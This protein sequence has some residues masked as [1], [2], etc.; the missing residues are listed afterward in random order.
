MSTAPERTSPTQN[1]AENLP[2][3]GVF[4][5]TIRHLG[6]M[7]NKVA[8]MFEVEWGDGDLH[9]FDRRVNPRS[10]SGR[11]LLLAVRISAGLSDK[12]DDSSLEGK[13]ISIKGERAY[14]GGTLD[15]VAKRFLQLGEPRASEVAEPGIQ[16]DEKDALADRMLRHMTDAKFTREGDDVMILLPG[17]SPIPIDPNS[18]DY[19]LL[20]HQH[21]GVGTR[22]YKGKVV[23]QR[24]KFLA[25]AKAGSFRTVQFSYADQE[26]VLV[27]VEGGNVLRIGADG[28]S[29]L[30]NGANGFWLAHPRKNPLPWQPDADPREGLDKFEELLIQTQPIPIEP[31]RFILGYALGI[32]PFLRQLATTRP[33][34]ELG[35]RHGEGKTS[36]GQ[37]YLTQHRL[38]KVKGNYSLALRERDGDVGLTVIDNVE[39]ADLNRH[40]ENSLLYAATGGEWGR[41]GA[42][43]NSNHPVIAVTT[44]EGVARR[45]ETARRLLNLDFQRE[46]KAWPEGQILAD[47]EKHGGLIFRGIAEVIRLTMAQ[48]PVLETNIIPMVDFT[49]Y[50]LL[51]YRALRA[52]E[53]V[54]EKPAGF[55]DSIFEAWNDQQH[56]DEGEDS[57]GS[58]PRLLDTLTAR[59]DVGSFEDLVYGQI[60]RKS[61]YTHGQVTGDLFVASPNDWLT[62]LKDVA[63]RDRHHGPLPGRPEGLRRRLEGLNIEAHGYKLLTDKDDKDTLAR[64]GSRRLWGILKVSLDEPSLDNSLILDELVAK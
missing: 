29:I 37:R 5:A 16:P 48:D 18:D 45:P 21:T 6:L 58:Y 51:A 22:E 13:R 17:R 40:I 2:P 46:H 60:Q 9:R 33:I 7:G 39:T 12:A 10:N 14:R 4:P 56:T 52:Y 15:W 62:A 20:Q 28:F 32:F 59:Q 11:K 30:E 8:L 57:A 55:A 19:G 36:T 27:P 1:G 53:Q 49:D 31:M 54:A 61:N 42:G 50:C 47:I 63:S 44:V 35:G 25:M 38:G 41:V 43:A 23:A 26:Q 3:D 64:R 34:S 24:V